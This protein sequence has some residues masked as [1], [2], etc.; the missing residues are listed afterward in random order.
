MTD[1]AKLL[2]LKIKIEEILFDLEWPNPAW[3]PTRLGFSAAR[4]TTHREER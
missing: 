4:R 2:A 1:D 3:P